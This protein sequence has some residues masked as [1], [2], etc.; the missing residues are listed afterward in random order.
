MCRTRLT[1]LLLHNP[2]TPTFEIANQ[3]TRQCSVQKFVRPDPSLGGGVSNQNIKLKIKRWVENQHFAMWCG[4]SSTHRQARK[5]ISGPS[6]TRKTRLLS[7]NRTQY[8]VLTGLLTRHNTL[9]RHLNLMGLI[10]SPLCG[11]CG[12]EDETSVHILCEYEALDSLIH[13]YLGSFTFGPRGYCE[14]K[15]GGQLELQQKNRAPLI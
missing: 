6:Q 8:R 4:P 3:L 12:A 15:P 10:N 5:L 2:P 7:S 9:R 13:A 1:P 11:K 14:S